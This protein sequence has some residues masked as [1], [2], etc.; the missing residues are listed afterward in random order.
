MKRALA[1]CCFGVA[2]FAQQAGKRDAGG[3]PAPT[4]RLERGRTVYVLSSCHFCHGIDLTGVAMGS[5]DLLH[6]A[7][8]GRDEGGNYIGVIVRSGLPNLQ[9]AMPQYSDYTNEQISDLAAYV[10]YLRRLGRYRELT[11]LPSL[12]SGDA[13]AGED[14]FKQNC[15]SCHAAPFASQETR[16]LA[17]RILRPGP[18]S[19]FSDEALPAGAAAHMKWL[20]RYTDVEFRNVLTYLTQRR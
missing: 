18:E 13:T 11:G 2:A 19:W 4:A 1:V 7:S 16:E 5:A 8:V 9:T 10:H 14:Y 20:E 3:V 15:A 6:V 12:D 17:R